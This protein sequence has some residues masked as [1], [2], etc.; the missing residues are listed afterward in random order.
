[1]EEFRVGRFFRR[2]HEQHKTAVG[3][4]IWRLMRSDRR[5]P[6]GEINPERRGPYETAYHVT[7]GYTEVTRI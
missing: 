6:A 5:Q 4:V 7:L 2:E 1:M 3:P